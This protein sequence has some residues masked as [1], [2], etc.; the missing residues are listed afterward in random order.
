MIGEHAEQIANTPSEHTPNTALNRP[1]DDPEQPSIADLAREQIAITPDNTA[2]VD[3]VMALRP[4][5]NRDSVAA[6]VRRERRKAEKK[7]GPYL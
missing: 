5:A 7:A 3:G 2:A 4:D 1:N 6:A